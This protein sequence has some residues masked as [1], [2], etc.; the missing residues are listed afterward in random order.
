MASL[1]VAALLAAGDPLALLGSNQDQLR[2][3]IG[4]ALS[5][6]GRLTA[7]GLRIAGIL[8]NSV[9]GAEALKRW[10]VV[11]LVPPFLKSESAELRNLAVLALTAISAAFPESDV[12]LKS[13][14]TLFE[15]ARDPTTESYPL[16]C[17]SNI[18]VD[19]A[20]A[21]AC[22]PYG[23]ELVQH[24]K[25]GT[26][27]SRKRA[28]VTIHRI[29]LTPEATSL[30]EGSA[31]IEMFFE[32][33]AD[34]WTTEQFPIVLDIAENLSG[35]PAGCQW[36]KGHGMEVM[37]RTRLLSCQLDDPCR[38]KLIRLRSRLMAASN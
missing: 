24:I 5:S 37:A 28:V 22:I 14:P 26:G 19:A 17:L 31:L 12:M 8:A 13:I 35:T 11:Q 1:S 36:M 3:F 7:S 29:L 16:I 9:S 6:D 32:A 38:P 21:A 25:N 27:L 2:G 15:L 33:A 30:P 18:A 34:W 4:S 23:A 20:N 10:K